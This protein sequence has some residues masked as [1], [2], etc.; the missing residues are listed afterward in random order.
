MKYCKNCGKEIDIKHTFCN[1]SCSAKYN[2]I[3]RVVH[4]RKLKECRRSIDRQ[5]CCKYCG[6]P[7][8]GLKVVCSNC[9]PFV[10]SK[11]LVQMHKA[12]GSTLNLTDFWRQTIERIALQYESGEST[13]TLEKQLGIPKETVWFNL[14]K[15]GVVRTL[16]EAGSNRFIKDRGTECLYN[17]KH[18]HGWH[19]SW[20]GILGFYRSSYELDYAK[21]LD[22][23]R[24]PYRI[25]YRD[26]FTKYYDS[27]LNRF[28]VARPDFYLPETQEVVEVKSSFTYD[29]QNMKDRFK[30]Y[31]ERGYIPKLLLEGKF[32]DL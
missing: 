13:L 9:K 5:V 16:S 8:T 12:S 11:R 25:E 19:E 26:A 30:S 1:S 21:S 14:K 18:C 4:S 27:Q 17:K 28:R 24:I 31:R 15:L 32:V 20:E 10:H 3:H 22:V 2:N 23:Q 29:E 7:V 6:T